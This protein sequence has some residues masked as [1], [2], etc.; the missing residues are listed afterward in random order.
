[1]SA[2]KAARRSCWRR[3]AISIALKIREIAE[4]HGI[5]IVEDKPLARSLYENVE[6]DKLIPPQ[7]YKAVAEI[8][9]FLHT[10]KCTKYNGGTKN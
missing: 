3:V 10:R 4:N 5:P 8:I 2:R 1:M 7:F 6:I 9:F